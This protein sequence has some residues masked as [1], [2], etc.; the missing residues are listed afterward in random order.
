MNKLL[1]ALLVICILIA[2]K[3]NAQPEYNYDPV[4]TA[5]LNPGAVFSLKLSHQESV[6]A[7]TVSP[8]TLDSLDV[9]ITCKD[10]VYHLNSQGNG[11]YT[12]STLVIRP[13]NQYDLRFIYNGEVVT[14]SA[15]VPSKPTGYTQ[16]CTEISVAEVSSGPPSP[17]SDSTV[18]LT[19]DNPNSSYYVVVLQ[20]TNYKPQSVVSNNTSDSG[21]VFG[22]D[23]TTG[24]GYNIYGMRFRYFGKYRM[25]LFH[26]NADYA[27]LYNNTIGTSQDLYTPSTGITNG[28][29]IFTGINSDTLYLQV[30][31]Q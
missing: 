28:V 30:D 17:Q 14:A 18:T 19:W 31:K 26:I 24:T 15:V 9:T 11:L 22:S 4:V 16:S 3:K 21:L 23:P 8:P 10:T 6:N 1:V 12:D 29:G 5:Y 20:D 27:S 2:C 7:Y 13:G 25:I